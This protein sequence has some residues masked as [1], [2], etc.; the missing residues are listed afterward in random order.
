MKRITLILFGVFLFSC[1]TQNEK[2]LFIN[3][4]S[5]CSNCIMF[6][7][8]SDYRTMRIE[9]VSSANW[10]ATLPSP[11]SGSTCF[12]RLCDDDDGKPERALGDSDVVT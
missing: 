2:D 10:K 9:R 3:D 11:T 5:G 4:I 7:W 12:S 8:L 1:S 6:L